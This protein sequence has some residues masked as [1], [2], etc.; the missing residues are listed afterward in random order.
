MNY[1]VY[2]IADYKLPTSQTKWDA[3]LKKM[4]ECVI[5]K[6]TGIN[7]IRKRKDD[8]LKALNEYKKRNESTSNDEY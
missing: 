3:M 8:F 5:D 6:Q 2:L 4:E 1:N 7:A